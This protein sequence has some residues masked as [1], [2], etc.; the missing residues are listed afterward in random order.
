MAN[1]LNQ[2]E[3]LNCV[4]LVSEWGKYRQKENMILTS[5]CYEGHVGDF[6]VV[7]KEKGLMNKTFN[8]SVYSKNHLI[9]EC[10]SKKHPQY[11]NDL[12][13]VLAKIENEYEQRRK[14]T[15]DKISKQNNLQSKL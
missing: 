4:A 8:V 3:T 14:D 5:I 7:A 12:V 15:I 9:G 13:V 2:Q 6:E 1:E 11:S 10:D